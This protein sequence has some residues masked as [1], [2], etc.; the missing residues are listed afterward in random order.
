[1]VQYVLTR[2]EAGLLSSIGEGQEATLPELAAA[3]RL[4][5]SQVRSV[6]A[7]LAQ[8]RLLS[9]NGRSGNGKAV[10]V[11]LTAD[12]AAARLAL[13]RGQMARPHRPVEILV[14]QGERPA[15]REEVDTMGLRELD[16]AIDAELCRLPDR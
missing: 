2:D 1:M 13:E 6:I 10:V 16:D 4:A 8:K 12:G 7:G 3:T 15:W 11:H 14:L 5:P 9:M